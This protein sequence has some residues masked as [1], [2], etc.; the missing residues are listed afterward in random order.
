MG[1]CVPHPR[2]AAAWAGGLAMGMT[3]QYVAGELSVLLAHLQAAA[4]TEAAAREAWS[5]RHAAETEPIPALRWVALSALALAEGLCWDSLNRGDTAALIQ[6]VYPRLMPPDEGGGDLLVTGRH[7]GEQRLIRQMTT[8]SLPRKGALVQIHPGGRNPRLGLP[9][10]D[11]REHEPSFEEQPMRPL[12]TFA[13]TIGVAALL[14]VAACG[15]NGY[16]SSSS[17]GSAQSL[18]ITSPAG[19]ASVTTPFTL[20]FT[21]S[22][23][24]GPTDSGKDHVHLFVDGKTNYQVVTA[25]RTQVKGLSPGKHTIRVTLQHADHSSDGAKAQITVIVTGGSGG[26]PSSTP[27][28][29]YGY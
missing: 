19:G 27:T 15:S 5:L 20:T 16:S 1:Q 12:L 26:T 18:K 24:I 14:A 22:A 11:T 25:T 2:G 23:P 4:T 10:Y 29:G 3:R 8:H 13:S 9:S 6:A 17:G 7:A 28:G 21:S